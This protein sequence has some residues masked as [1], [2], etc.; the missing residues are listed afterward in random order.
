MKVRIRSTY[1]IISKRLRPGDIVVSVM[2][3]LINKRAT[4][5]LGDILS[6]DEGLPPVSSSGVDF[7]FV[8]DGS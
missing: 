1:I 2:R 6:G 3:F 8:L 7:A 5:D 4:S